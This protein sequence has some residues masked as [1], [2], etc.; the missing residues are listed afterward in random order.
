MSFFKEKMS[1][2]RKKFDGNIEGVDLGAFNSIYDDFISS[3]YKKHDLP[4]LCLWEDGFVQG[5]ASL[6]NLI[7]LESE[8]EKMYDAEIEFCVYN[9]GDF[10][11]NELLTFLDIK[12]LEGFE[13]KITEFLSKKTAQQ[14]QFEQVKDK[15]QSAVN[16]L[17][18][19]LKLM[20]TKGLSK[21][22]C[23][24]T[25]ITYHVYELDHLISDIEFKDFTP[26]EHSGDFKLS[27]S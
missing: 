18:D 19:I 8:L 25:G 24:K 20:P 5:D 23:Q 11:E 1:E 15:L 4:P 10:D 2:L 13:E 9:D 16:N 22:D 7:E 14:R 21:Y 17:H 12:L 6:N 26:N 3:F 27:Y